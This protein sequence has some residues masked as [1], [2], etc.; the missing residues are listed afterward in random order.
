M[1]LC[2]GHIV[3]FVCWALMCSQAAMASNSLGET[4]QGAMLS[5]M[6]AKTLVCFAD[7]IEVSILGKSV[8]CSNVQAVAFLEEFMNNH[9]I[10]SCKLLHRGKKQT[11]GF[12]ILSVQSDAQKVF[13]VYALERTEQGQNLIRQFRIDEVIE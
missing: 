8:V 3:T 4:L 6:P 7:N 12:Y 2:K 11:S 5:N 13:R 9:P 10:A 1:K